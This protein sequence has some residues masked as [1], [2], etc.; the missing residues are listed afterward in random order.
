MFNNNKSIINAF[1][2]NDTIESDFI[3]MI[4]DINIDK[5]KSF[6]I[7]TYSFSSNENNY[8]DIKELFIKL[9]KLDHT[10]LPT[11]LT[12]DYRILQDDEML[13]A[14]RQKIGK[15]IAPSI[16]IVGDNYELSVKDFQKLYFAPQI[17]VDHCSDDI[18]NAIDIKDR[19]VEQK[20]IFTLDY[21]INNEGKSGY[22]YF[23]KK[24]LSSE[25][26]KY[27]VNEINNGEFSEKNYVNLNICFYNPTKYL[28]F[29]NKLKDAGLNK[30]VSISFLGNPLHDNALVFEKIKNIVPNKINI[31]YNTCQDMINDYGKE[32]FCTTV[33]H[34]SEIEGG[35]KT[36]LDNYFNIL[37]MLDE[38][39]K[40]VKD[41]NYSPLE[42][43]IYGYKFIKERYIYDPD[44]ETTDSID[45]ETNRSLHNVV[46]RDKI[47]CVGYSTL[48]SALM[49]R[50][51]IP[52]FRYSTNSHV[53]NITRI[54]D[55]KY[56][57][58]NIQVTDPTWD[59]CDIDDMHK[60]NMNLYTNFLFSPRETLKYKNPEY[61][62]IASSLVLDKDTADKY[63]PISKSPLE[64]MYHTMYDPR[65]Y[66]Y[67]MLQLMGYNL[68]DDDLYNLV[69]QL[70]QN[71]SLDT[72]DPNIIL[73]AIKN[74]ELKENPLLSN[75]ELNAILDEAKQSF[76]DRKIIFSNEKEQIQINYSDNFTELYEGEV[77][78]VDVTSI[79]KD[80]IR[81]DFDN[82]T[83]SYDAVDSIGIDDTIIDTDTNDNINSDYKDDN[84][85]VFDDK[86]IA[87]TNIPKPRN[88]DNYET[89]E[90]YISYLRNYYSK[91]FPVVNNDGKYRIKNKYEV[92]QDDLG[93]YST[94]TDD[95]K[96]NTH[97]N[98]K[99]SR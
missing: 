72:I 55:E 50:C 89:D 24:E 59:S 9:L 1:Y 19:V 40:N 78:N 61:F 84:I 85:K 36:D 58:D 52:T 56:G 15:D 14:I 11:V 80:K 66:T 88:R 42:T 86:Y 63:S 65:D 8:N 35:G 6:G 77:Y 90:H 87:G 51:G 47:V 46:N 30:D 4:G 45:Y 26:V 97:D 20:N 92:F 2:Y 73:N 38:F 53:R 71:G 39:E 37:N 94:I 75:E 93:S 22:D 62:N 82:T 96:D 13:N 91:H 98:V 68:E 16:R 48:Y 32:P 23:I 54:K 79:N 7:G 33:N 34:R 81:N 10:I 17:I 69:N 64:D 25:E 41:K 67:R 27:L 76:I 44:A 95:I 28:D 5:S 29:L 12:L 99:K 60:H 83:N 49:R 18:K 21:G 70:N 57:V 43:Q 31:T 74:V 3:K